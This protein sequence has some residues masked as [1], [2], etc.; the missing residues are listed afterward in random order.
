[1]YRGS[2]TGEDFLEIRRCAHP[3]A[4]E[5]LAAYRREF[6]A[7]V[8]ALHERLVAKQDVSRNQARIEQAIAYIDANFASDLNMA[9]VSNQISMNYSLFSYL[10]KLRTGESFVTYLKQIRV[11][12]AQRLL[13]ETDMKILDISH[14]VGY[15]NEKHFMK[16]FRTF[17]GVS[18]SEYRRNMRP[19]R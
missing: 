18:P 12:E 6:L 1:M 11:R 10:F 8:H 14:Q 4:F 7:W 9:V 5:N 2:L 13:V 3:L 17:S 19:S 15:A 16:V